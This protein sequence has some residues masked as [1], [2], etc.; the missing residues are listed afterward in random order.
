VARR[1]YGPLCEEA[2]CPNSADTLDH[3]TLRGPRRKRLRWHGC[4]PRG[5]S[6][7]S[8][9]LK[10][11][12]PIRPAAGALVIMKASPSEWPALGERV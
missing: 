5:A 1:K 9:P 4:S 11:E 8:L 6:G 12:N 3:T 2:S 7:P 10:S